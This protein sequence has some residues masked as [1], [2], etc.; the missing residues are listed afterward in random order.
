MVDRGSA[1]R[2]KALLKRKARFRVLAM[3]NK[4]WEKRSV[5]SNYSIVTII[6]DRFFGLLNFY[7]RKMNDY[8]AVRNDLRG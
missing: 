4:S 2:E 1:L 7:F 6:S 3:N 8:T 5:S